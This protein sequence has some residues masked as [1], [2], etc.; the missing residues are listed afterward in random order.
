MP[1]YHDYDYLFAFSMIG[2]FVNAYGIGANDVANSFA[3]SVSSKSLTFRQAMVCAAFCEFLGAVLV[4]ARVASTIKNGIIDLDVFNGNAS[5]V[6]LAFTCSIIGSASWLTF[7]TRNA[8]PVSTTHT[9]VG[10]VIGVGIAVSGANGV[11]WGWN[12]VAQIFA[13]WGIAPAVAGVCAACVYLITKLV[14][15]KSRNPVMVGLWTAPVYFFIVS[16]VLTVSIIV[17]GSPS[18]NLDELPPSTTIAAVLGTA[19]VVALL[20]ILFWLPYVHGKVVKGDY[21]LKW[22]HFFMG[23]LLW[24]RPAPEDA[25][26]ADMAV[27]DYKLH[28]FDEPAEQQAVSERTAAAVRA[29]PVVAGAALQRIDHSNDIES[30]ANSDTHGSSP[31]TEEKN[32]KLVQPGFCNDSPSHLAR[33][34]AELEGAHALP[35]EHTPGRP[36]PP[37]YRTFEGS[38]L[39]P[40]NLYTI[41]RYNMLPWM[42]YSVSAGLRTDIHAMQA[43]GSEKEK[44]KLRQMHAVAE[45]YDNRVE[46]LYSFMQVMTACTASFAHGANDVSNAIGPLAVVYSIWSTSLFP[47][48]K[49]PV[50]IWILA[51]G[52]A[53][54]VIG[55]GTYGWK[56]MSV[57]GN[58]LTMHSPS[59]GFSMEL[60]A[61]I[62]VVIAS[63][64]G[65]PVSSTQSITGATLAVGLCNGDYK[66]MNWKMLAWIFFS[67]ILTL[68]IAGLISGC[69]LAI[70]L[71]APSWYT[72]APVL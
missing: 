20:S 61:S 5:V 48:S 27:P 13:S 58:R 22:Y 15:L 34:E 29:Q 14:V 57:L 45:Q 25:V 65:L 56:L 7:A 55:L 32:A 49:E 47:E 40:W 46:H 35:A 19:S 52:G 12:G 50:P 60:G 53:A 39:E 8:M 3:T 33:V 54:I 23:P 21:T 59:R 67:W 24:R 28:D 69:L 2:A 43:H 37:A 16:G 4:G 62:T 6:L 10:S 63:Y 70:V 68:P 41:I 30:G 1:K 36:T 51:F 17:K 26:T 11:K 44:A 31:S 18:L 9:T 71:N 38:W 64:L 72:P 42:W 66:A